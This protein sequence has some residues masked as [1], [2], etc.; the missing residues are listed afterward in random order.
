MVMIF[1]REGNFWF[2]RPATEYV[3][4]NLNVNTL[5]GEGMKPGF[6]GV[7]GSAGGIMEA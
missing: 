6:S 5:A 7:R 2:T 1:Q 3:F 4:S